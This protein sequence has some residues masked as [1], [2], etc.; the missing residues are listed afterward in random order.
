MPIGKDSLFNKWC[1]ENWMATCRRMKWDHFLTPYT[2]IKSKWMK[3]PKCETGI[4]QNPGGE[5]L[6]DLSP[7]A[8]ESKNEVVG[9]HQD[10]NLLHNK[11]N[12][13]QN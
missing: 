11:G 10:K 6:L 9:L 12:S 7:K 13:Q 1:L 2:K 3:R 8:R 5:F 4:H